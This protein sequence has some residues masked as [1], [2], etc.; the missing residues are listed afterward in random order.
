MKL[1]QYNK[2]TILLKKYRRRDFLLEITFDEYAKSDLVLYKKSEG[3]YKTV[4]DR[5]NSPGRI[6][7]I[8]E[9][10][11]TVKLAKQNLLEM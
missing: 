10:E 8:D 7:K 9:N 4:K 3:T 6:I 5:F 1:D 2:I 11:L